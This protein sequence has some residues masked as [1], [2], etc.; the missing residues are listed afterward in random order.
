LFEIEVLERDAADIVRKALDDS[1]KGKRPG[2]A[3]G[4][5]P[6]RKA[7][8]QVPG[9]DG[10]PGDAMGIGDGDDNPFDSVIQLKKSEIPT[11]I[12]D[13]VVRLQELND[14]SILL[15][16]LLTKQD[17]FGRRIFV[18][19]EETRYFARKVRPFLLKN[20]RLL[21][22]M[23][24]ATSG[25]GSEWVPRGFSARL[26]ELIQSG[27]T[28]GSEF[29]QVD[30]P[31]GSWEYPITSGRPTAYLGSEQA[32]DEAAKT[33]A[34]SNPTTGRVTLT[35]KK[36][37]I[38]VPFSEELEED[39]IV[40]VLPALRANTAYHL[41]RNLEDAI[42]N[43]DTASPH[44]DND[45]TAATDRRKAWIGLRAQAVDL[46]AAVRV[47]LSTFSAAK[48]RQL[49]SVMVE[50]AI[51]DPT[52]N[53]VLVTG[54]KAYFRHFSDLANAAR[55]DPRIGGGGLVNVGGKLMFD[56]IPIKASAVMREDLNTVGVR[57]STTQDNSA[58]L[59]VHKP[60][61]KLATLRGPRMRTWLST[62]YDQQH[63]I[64]DWRGT[65]FTPWTTT[66][67]VVAI[68]VD[69]DVS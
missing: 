7:E 6:L 25:E 65:L 34:A 47:S 48:L 57:D 60:S 15:A 49:L 33:Y 50:Y 29:E 42:L 26:F 54:P 4:Q 18:R 19:P 13:D 32:G 66:E 61:W 31:R 2:K 12:R 21:K 38:R 55:T 56:G 59:A 67:Q 41:A 28:V 14:N 39:S 63:L 51:D 30:M 27:M 53:L 20:D 44:M 10:K 35:A 17:D 22:Q 46:G 23:D 43:G 64:A 8:H 5:T 16:S 52:N 3:G 11:D 40:P 45:V 62:L 1:A 69:I 24:T 9:E 36:I 68:G 37:G 58:V